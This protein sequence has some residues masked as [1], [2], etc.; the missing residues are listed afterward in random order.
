MNKNVILGI[1]G[2]IAAYKA[3]ELAS[4][5]VKQNY[6][7]HVIMTP[8]AT[9]F[10]TP[11]TLQAISQNPVHV[12]MFAS[13]G[14]WEIGHVSL[15][16]RA[17]LIL[18]APATADF[19]ARLAAGLADD[20]LLATIMAT[21]AP[22]LL[23]PAMNDG[24][25]A[26]PVLQEKIAYLKGIGYR[27]ID[28]ESGRLA[29][30]SVG[31]GRLASPDVI[32]GAVSQVF[33]TGQD[34]AGIR[35]LVTAGPT[36]EPLDPVRFLS[37]YSSGKMGHAIAEEASRRGAEVTLVSGPTQLVP[38]PGVN[39]VPVETA[40]E[41]FEAVVSRYDQVDAVIKAAAVADFRPRQKS[42]QK[43]KKQVARPVLELERTPDILS[44]LGEHKSGQVL[45]GF[46]A[47][48]ENLLENAGDKLR[49]KNLDLVV[50]ND[51][52]EPGAGFGVDTNLVT[53]LYS[54]GETIKL[55]VLSK[56]EVAGILLDKVAAILQAK[57]V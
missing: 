11:L 49:Q 31:Q 30:G 17:G 27:F 36:R 13:P 42:G 29:C 52:T 57:K 2:S 43:L 38:P 21:R 50:A 10:I 4:L 24:M 51:L 8:A 46:A 15:A 39:L 12:D 48:T 41:M 20:L 5:L 54:C 16:G 3:A 45:V 37:N 47:E 6:A 19:I 14:S 28:P 1:T 23:A 56:K 9:R 40:Q 34:L 22:V 55:P 53:L 7:V 35:I 32:I 26:N 44:Y 25:Y 18:V 33:S